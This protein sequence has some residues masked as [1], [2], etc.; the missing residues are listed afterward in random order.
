MTTGQ[1]RHTL[2]GHTSVVWS[3]SFSPDGRTCASISNAETN[4]WDVSTGQLLHTFEG[5]TSRWEPLLSSSLTPFSYDPFFSPTAFSPDGRTFANVNGTEINLWDV[6]TGQ[7]LHTFEG[8]TRDV[9]RVSFS[10]DGQ[11][12][13]SASDAREA[14]SVRVWDVLTSSHL[15]T[16][17]NGNSFSFSPD[18][19]I[20]TSINGTE[21]NLWDVSTWELLS[22]LRGHT[23]NVGDVFFSPDGS[24]LAS[25]SE[26]GG[27][28]F[29][30]D[31][32]AV[33]T[34]KQSHLATD[35]NQDGV[36]NIQDL[37]A[38]AAAIGQSGENA[39][40][41]NGDGEVNIQDL[42]A[43][44]AALGQVA[45]STHR[46]PPTSHSTSDNRRRAA[47]ESH[48]HNSSTLRHREH[49]AAFCSFNTFWRHS[50]RKRRYCWRTTRTRSTQRH[51][52]PY[53]LA[54]PADVSIAIYAID[55]KLVRALD[56]GHQPVGIYESKSRGSVLG[57]QKRCR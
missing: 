53:Q 11:L 18:G 29:L 44:A 37:V 40:D 30:W 52:Y 10:P 41:V 56:L 8:H 35:V 46:H 16:F 12:L 39:A 21:I 3:A 33:S 36:V 13:V 32:T 27:L 31:V 45:A 50:R 28:L 4:L 34:P 43:V 48:R 57:W 6:T 7:V 2:E 19:Q 22:T 51:G 49:N 1:L 17:Y 38:V 15:H 20:F 25:V 55:G 42:V 47:L 24:L 23:V 54:N 14:P 26:R 5:H 9:W